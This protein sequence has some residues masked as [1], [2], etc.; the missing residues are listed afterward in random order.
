MADPSSQA[1]YPGLAPLIAKR[2]DEYYYETRRFPDDALNLIC[3]CAIFSIYH[4]DMVASLFRGDLTKNC[5]NTCEENNFSNGPP[6]TKNRDLPNVLVSEILVSSRCSIPSTQYINN[7]IVEIQAPQSP[8]SLRQCSPLW[9]LERQIYVF[10][11]GT[12]PKDPR[13]RSGNGKNRV[14]Q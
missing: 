11:A 7:E 2:P 13:N 3:C 1:R 9:T 8:P 12:L 6:I 14:T 4:P 5:S 10:S